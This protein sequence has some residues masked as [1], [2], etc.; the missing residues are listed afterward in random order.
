MSAQFTGYARKLFYFLESR[1]KYKEYPTAQQG[2]FSISLEELQYLLDYPESYRPVDVKRTI[3]QR[4]KNNFDNARG[5][6]F[7]FDYEDKKIGKKIVGFLFKVQEIKPVVEI[8]NKEV[9]EQKMIENDKQRDTVFTMLA[10][11]GL[12]DQECEDVYK[13]YKAQNR[14]VAFLI[15]AIASVSA[16]ANINSK[17]A[18]LCYIMDNCIING[19]IEAIRS[20]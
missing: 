15:S 5:I 2:I 7:T 3:L 6:D 14:D 9:S 17:C 19:I 11:I 4:A 8:E 20:V 16:S 13:K 1:K 18:V 10:S 12:N